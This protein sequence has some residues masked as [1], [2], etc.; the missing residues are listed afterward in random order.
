MPTKTTITSV[1]FLIS[2]MAAAAR[3]AKEQPWISLFDGKT[4]KGWNVSPVLRRLL[5]ATCS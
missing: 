4:L 2:L 5:T 1:F 3:D